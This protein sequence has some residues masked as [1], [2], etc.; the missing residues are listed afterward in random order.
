MIMLRLNREESVKMRVGHKRVMVCKG[1][2]NDFCAMSILGGE[3]EKFPLIWGDL[4]LED[5][6]QQS[7]CYFFSSSVKNGVEPGINLWTEQMK[8]G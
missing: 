4:T 6:W 2:N 7:R 5:R 1:T 3:R 8:A